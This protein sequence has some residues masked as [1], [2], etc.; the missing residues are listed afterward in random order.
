MYLNA[1]KLPYNRFSHAGN[2][3]VADFLVYDIKVAVDGLCKHL[4]RF[5]E[6]ISHVYCL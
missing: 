1:F 4:L 2:I 6:L 5:K 3:V